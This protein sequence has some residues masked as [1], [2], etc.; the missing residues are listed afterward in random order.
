MSLY[1]DVGSIHL[2]ADVVA[3]VSSGGQSP[4]TVTQ[5]HVTA[6]AESETS[7]RREEHDQ[8]ADDAGDPNGGDTE[9]LIEDYSEH[10]DALSGTIESGDIARSRVTDDPDLRDGPLWLPV[11]DF[12]PGSDGV[13]ADTTAAVQGAQAAGASE[14]RVDIIE[15]ASQLTLD[16]R[17]DAA[18]TVTASPDTSVDFSNGDE[19]DQTYRAVGTGRGI[20]VVWFDVPTTARISLL[21]DC[22][23]PAA[24]SS[25]VDLTRFVGQ[26]SNTVWTNDTCGSISEL[27]PGAYR[28]EVS[29]GVEARDDRGSPSG[30]VSTSVLLSVTT[31]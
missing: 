2:I 12:A 21:S 13:I 29:A 10:I 27:E 4:F 28:L 19:L 26:L 14:A 11:G 25:T 16:V 18:A 6:R 20:A 23:G 7:F 5:R 24:P 9:T 15:T 30:G 3:Y 8:S 22:L 17:A 31:L 1:N